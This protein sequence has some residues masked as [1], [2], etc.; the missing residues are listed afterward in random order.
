MRNAQF[1]RMKSAKNPMSVLFPS[2]ALVTATAK[3][4]ILALVRARLRF[5]SS[6]TV[7]A[8]FSSSG[9]LAGTK[10]KGNNLLKKNSFWCNVV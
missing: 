9:S 1:R 3:R 5:S 10:M 4:G 2:L 7:R 6:D 8:V